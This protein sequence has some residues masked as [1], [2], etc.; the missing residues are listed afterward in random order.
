MPKLLVLY[1]FHIYND[2]VKHFLNN[3]IFNDENTDFIIIS[4]DKNNRFTVPDNIKLLFRDNIGYDFGGW[5]DALLIDNLYDKYEKF[6]FVN[7]SVS[8]PFLPSYYKGKWTDIYINGL[9]DNIKLFGSTINTICQP[10]SLSH[11]QSYIFSMDK[12]TLDY[13]IKCEIFSMT[14]YAKTFRDAIHNKEILMSRKIIENKWNIGSLLPCYKNID[15]T[16]TSKQPHECN[17]NFLDDVMYPEFR[18]SLWNEYD[19]VFIKGNR[20][21]IDS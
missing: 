5:S 12:I 18:K 4:N 16:F 17:I 2:R 13:L 20:V 11:V 15:F 21:I 9:Q 8:G 7:S 6:I 14:N 19:L 3:C 10:Q 1:V